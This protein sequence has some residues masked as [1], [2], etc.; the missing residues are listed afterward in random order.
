MGGRGSFWRFRENLKLRS[1]SACN[2]PTRII[3]TIES[4][5]LNPYMALFACAVAA[6]IFS[7]ITTTMLL[8]SM[9]KEL[10]STSLKYPLIGPM[11]IFKVASEYRQNVRG[12]KHI[13]FYISFGLWVLSLLTVAILFFNRKTWGG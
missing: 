2:H 3:G 6:Q 11:D 4:M 1:K 10:P 5:L 13:H 12:R 8:P 7:A 9:W